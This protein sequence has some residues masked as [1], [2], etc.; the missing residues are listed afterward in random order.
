M[1]KKLGVIIY[2]NGAMARV[3]FSFAKHQMNIVAFTVDD[4][5]IDEK[6]NMFCGLPLIPFS[7]VE[8]IY[9]PSKYSMIIACGYLEMNDLR[10]KKYHE[11]KEKGFSFETY[12]HDS[13]IYHDDVV[14]EENCIVLDHVSIH[15]GC[16]VEN[17]TFISSNVNIG[18][19]CHIGR[20]NWINS[21]VSIAGGSS[22]GA[23]CFVGVNACI[24]HSIR[25]GEQ[26]FV[27][28]NTLLTKDTCEGEVFLSES[29]M[30]F[31]L[32]SKSFLKFSSSLNR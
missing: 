31:K 11:S 2:G 29:G 13:L 19:D 9:S 7:N 32:N 8:E 18:H 3:L 26:N 14:I 10:E 25:I 1:G 20:T 22:I 5:C 6:E 24:G 17:S 28:A 21:G 16:R 27:G 23:R 12:V 30:K 15:T 4:H